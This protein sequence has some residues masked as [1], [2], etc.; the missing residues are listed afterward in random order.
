MN[1]YLDKLAQMLKSYPTDLSGIKGE[2]L[3]PS[4]FNKLQ[5]A[6]LLQELQGR[7]L[8]GGNLSP[9]EK[10]GQGTASAM[11]QNPNDF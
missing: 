2:Q 5:Q 8:K 9:M 6:R 11:A 1:N 3:N 4:M 7:Y 10:F